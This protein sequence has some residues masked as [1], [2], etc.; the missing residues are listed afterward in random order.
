MAYSEPLAIF[1]RDT[2]RR[3][4]MHERSRLSLFLHPFHLPLLLPS[5][6]TPTRVD[7]NLQLYIKRLLRR[8]LPLNFGVLVPSL[9]G[10]RSVWQ[11]SSSLRAVDSRVWE[12]WIGL[13]FLLR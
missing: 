2:Q 3:R 1:P 4:R 6:L 9:V 10:K 7:F 13:Y 12:G 8:W 5:L 11:R